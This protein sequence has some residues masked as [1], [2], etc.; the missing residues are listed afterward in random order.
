MRLLRPHLFPF[1][2]NQRTIETERERERERGECQIETPFPRCCPPFPFL[3]LSLSV[4]LCPLSEPSSG[5]VT[6]SK[7]VDAAAAT[8]SLTPASDSGQRLRE[9]GSAR[10]QRC[11]RHRVSAALSEPL[12]WGFCSFFLASGGLVGRAHSHT[13]NGR[14]R[15]RDGVLWVLYAS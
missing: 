8:L 11:L 5:V 1:F 3:S 13:F 9:S 12:N 15:R 6:R 4:C 10:S 7:G 2:F 14:R